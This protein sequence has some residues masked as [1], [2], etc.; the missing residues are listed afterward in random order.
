MDDDEDAAMVVDVESKKK[1]IVYLI[2][3][4]TGRQHAGSG[5]LTNGQQQGLEL[6]RDIILGVLCFRFLQLRALD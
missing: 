6:Y 5:L 4:Y 3:N 2:S 1:E